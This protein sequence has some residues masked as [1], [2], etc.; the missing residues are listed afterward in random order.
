MHLNCRGVVKKKMMFPISIQDNNV[1]VNSNRRLIKRF[2]LVWLIISFFLLPG[3][4]WPSILLKRLPSDVR[5]AA[6]FF[7]IALGLTFVLGI[8]ISIY[9]KFLSAKSGLLGNIFG[10]ILL[11][12]RMFDLVVLVLVHLLAVCMAGAVWVNLR[13]LFVGS[14]SKAPIWMWCFA[15]AFLAYLV[16]IIVRGNTFLPSDIRN[17]GINQS[18]K[19]F[20]YLNTF[21]ALSSFMLSTLIGLGMAQLIVFYFR[22]H[23][24]YFSNLNIRII[25]SFIL[26]FVVYDLTSFISVLY[27]MKLSLIEAVFHN[28]MR[29]WKVAAKRIQHL[30]L[31]HPLTAAFFCTLSLFLFCFVVFRIGYGVNDDV[32]LIAVASGYLGGKPYPFLIFS[33]VILGFALNFL[34]QFPTQI[35]WE[36]WL[37]IAV[38]FM[39]VSALLYILFSR[40]PSK[41]IVQGI[42]ILIVLSG[43]IYFLLNITFTTVAAVASIAGFCLILMAARSDACRVEYSF[44]WGVGL[45]FVASLIRIE[46][47]GFVFLIILP[48]L[49]GNFRSFNLQDLVK[50]LGIAGLLVLG[51]YAFDKFYLNLFPNWLS[52]NTYTLTRSMLHDTPRLANIDGVIRDVNWS[53]NDLNVFSRWFFPD[54]V[55][56][57][58]EN[59]RYLV[60]HVS[61]KRADVLSWVFFLPDYLSSLTVLPYT[62]MIV[63]L[64]LCI[65]VYGVDLKRT[66]G[67]SVLT[68]GFI[69]LT[70]IYLEW[71]QKAPNRILLFSI[72]AGIT[73]SL[74]NWYWVDA[75]QLEESV[76][77]TVDNSQARSG[78]LSVFF[79]L[80]M[81]IGVIFQ[82]SIQ[83]TQLNISHQKAYEQILADIRALQMRGSISQ[84]ALIVSA[85]YG[86][87]WEWSN[88]I[89]LEFPSIQYLPT[90][91]E[92]FS[93]AYNN[94]LR[95]FQIQSLPISLFKDSSIYL[96]ADTSTMR[97]IIQFIK[98]HDGVNV[99]AKIIYVIPS[100]FSQGTVYDGVTLF[101][102]QQVPP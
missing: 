22:S 38:H 83:T 102:L 89:F 19:R 37:F 30:I 97:G 44:I 88:P 43:E 40:S 84:K 78:F 62:I 45:I 2:M 93:P 73:F 20:F 53:A 58:L 7:I 28:R 54:Q 94:V 72:L 95:E 86:I 4:I 56:Y 90:N 31:T 91:W 59:L 32:Q 36:I 68:I 9:L 55:T 25:L 17:P 63:S 61:D 24:T 80:I 67:V 3:L 57:S 65:L 49:V 79:S 71:T 74:V 42:G 51:V 29:Y 50:F 33:N 10:T 23:D 6:P 81:M 96:M 69:V 70:I 66:L 5:S 14:L 18:L 99:T 12:P 82:Q 35:N 47:L 41:W 21:R 8:G 34:Y 1:M 76:T 101:K 100:Q 48:F 27:I 85:A 15:L 60:D 64:W 16:L 52:Y 87:P 92:T 98:E 77:P 39:S 46:S 11:L 75:K 13:L 26:P